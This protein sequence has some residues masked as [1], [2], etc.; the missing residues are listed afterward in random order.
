MMIRAKCERGVNDVTTINMNV[1]ERYF[2]PIISLCT[3]LAK[4][5]QV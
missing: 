1:G 3:V 2:M 4:I 5:I